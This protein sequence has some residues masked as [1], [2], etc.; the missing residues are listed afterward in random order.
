MVFFF[1]FFFMKSVERFYF[2]FS[3]I[4]VLCMSENIW[5]IGAMTKISAF[6]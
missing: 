1:F 2:S 6:F 4:Y 5:M 3:R